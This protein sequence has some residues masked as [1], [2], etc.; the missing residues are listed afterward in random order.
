M[1][2]EDSEFSGVTALVLTYLWIK[3]PSAGVS[4]TDLPRIQRCHQPYVT[5]KLFMS[6]SVIS[7]RVVSFLV[8]M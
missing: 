1:V 3:C 8:S 2:L 4:V 5:E 7:A 6:T